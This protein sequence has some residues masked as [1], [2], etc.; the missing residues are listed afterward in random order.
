MI[1]GPL[2]YA[3]YIAGL[4]AFQKTDSIGLPLAFSAIMGLGVRPALDPSLTSG[5]LD[6]G[7]LDLY[8]CIVLYTSH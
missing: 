2:G 8:E 1:F 6:L 3:F 7:R 5:I 4:I